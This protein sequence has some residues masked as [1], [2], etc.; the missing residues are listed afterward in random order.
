M[1]RTTRT[2][3]AALVALAIAAP[4][5]SAAPNRDQAPTSSLAGTSA[6]RQDLRN[7]DE[8]NPMP[9]NAPRFVAKP[10]VQ[11][12]I[13]QVD[14]DGTSPLLF[15]LPSLGLAAMAGAGYVR[16]QHTRVRRSQV[17]A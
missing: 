4:A 8:R 14:G 6:P 17:S 7:P 5:A 15:I 10:V 2:I 11:T 9:G 16:V 13:H 12:P 3:S 1:S